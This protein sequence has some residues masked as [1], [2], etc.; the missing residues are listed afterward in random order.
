MANISVIIDA[1]MILTG[2]DSQKTIN[3]G[4]KKNIFSNKFSILIHS[5][6]SVTTYCVSSGY[7]I[8]YLLSPGYVTGSF[9]CYIE[10]TNSVKLNKFKATV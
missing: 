5:K 4:Y 9:H 1:I 8:L 7:S 2:L 6:A 10:I 3:I